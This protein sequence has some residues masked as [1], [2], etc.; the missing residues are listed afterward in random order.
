MTATNDSIEPNFAALSRA[1]VNRL[2]SA[3]AEGLDGAVHRDLITVARCGLEGLTAAI[4]TGR[5]VP[6]RTVARLEAIA[7]RMADRELP[8][9][10]IQH[11]MHAGI[12]AGFEL[13]A[14]VGPR[15]VRQGCYTDG[16]RLIQA[17]QALSTAVLRGYV[18]EV[19]AMT[20][21]HR[22]AAQ[23]LVSA[24]LAGKPDPTMAHRCG[25]ELSRSYFVVAVALGPH[26]DENDRRLDSRV[27]AR[28]KLRRVQ[29]E[30]ATIRECRVLSMLSVDGGTILIPTEFAAD[31][32]ERLNNLVA[33]LT[34]AAA[35]PITATFTVSPRSRIRH[36]ADRVHKLLDL[37]LRLGRGPG[38]HRFE[39]LAHEY[40]LI[41][42]G[43][44]YLHLCAILD[45]LRA[46]PGLL[47]TLRTYFAAQ[48][49]RAPTARR[50]GVSTSAVRRRL[51][52][53]AELTGLDPENA[54]DAWYL[55]S[56]LVACTFADFPSSQ[57]LGVALCLVDS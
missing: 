28:R 42:P 3:P 49:K 9:A 32:E 47:D 5:P 22:V 50:L 30:L 10:L 4:R 13:V 37:A 56:S 17:T 23:T 18:G 12:K 15:S 27:V 19:R 14:S 36:A 41:Q 48:G 38:L 20:G 43:P 46:E 8:I 24:L 39:D 34:R 54:T 31:L 51:I 55:R 11:V 6:E 25:T 45:P 26:P 35:A 53:I 57:P 21:D 52:R 29:A 44:G 2:E 33:R 16:A 7:A 40:Q 1:I